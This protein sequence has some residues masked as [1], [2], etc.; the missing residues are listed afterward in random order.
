MKR[1]F[2]CFWM[3]LVAVVASAERVSTCFG[4]G[5]DDVIVA[6]IDKESGDKVIM[7]K[8]DGRLE[9]S[10]VFVG[11][12]I[13]LPDGSVLLREDWVEI[14]GGRASVKPA[15]FDKDF[16]SGAKFLS[17]TVSAPKPL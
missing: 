16:P 17:V 2:V 5:L 3:A 8:G 9:D 11:A 1:I 12:V 4:V 10:S 13:K 14:H 7:L 6:K 15:Y